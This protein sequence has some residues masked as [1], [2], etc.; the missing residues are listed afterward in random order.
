M[1]NNIVP[2]QFSRQFDIGK[3]FEARLDNFFKQYCFVY[4][5]A[6]HEQRQGIDRWFADE[7]QGFISVEYKADSK[8]AK[9]G[10]AFVETVSVDTRNIS[11]WAHTSIADVLCYYV[12]PTGKIWLIDFLELRR[13]LPDWI[14]KY[15]IRKVQNSDYCTHGVLVPL[16][17]FADIAF[18][19]F[20]IAC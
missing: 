16:Q 6:A 20:E 19:G 9:T 8:A 1:P 2:Y 18:E 13:F 12:P 10:N 11:G 15:P 17:K 14:E 7:D 4:A 5:A 3:D